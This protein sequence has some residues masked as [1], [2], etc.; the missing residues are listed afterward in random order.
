MS[1]ALRLRSIRAPGTAVACLPLAWLWYR[2][3]DHL[4]IEWSVNPQYSYGYAVP[5][6][7]LVLLWQR[8]RRGQTKEPGSAC[9]VSVFMNRARGA[10][11]VLLAILLLP[12]RLIQEANPEWRLMSW[13]FALTVIVLTLLVLSRH[14]FTARE[15]AFPILFFLVAVP[16]PSG[17]ETW[18]I[19][20]LT[21]LNVATTIE[22]LGFLNVPAF[23]HGSVI[24]I[25]TGSVG[26][27]EACSGLRSF[28]ATLMVSL[29]LGELYRLTVLRR[30]GLCLFGFGL[31]FIFN[32]SRITLLTWVAAKKGSAAIGSWHDSAGL[33][34]LGASLFT[35]W[36]AALL[37]RGQPSTA[38]VQTEHTPVSRI[39]AS[40][41]VPAA[42]CVWLGVVEFGTEGWYRAHEA[43]LGP[44][45]TW[46]VAMPETNPTF[47]SPPLSERAKQIL[48]YNEAQQGAWE[49]DAG[50]NWHAIFLHWNPG[51][52]AVHLAKGH[53]PEVCLT[54]AGHD[55]SWQ[56]ESHTF[57]V[58]GLEL[59][60]R[61]YV[62]NE[63]EG[64]VHV[65]YCLW[66]DHSPT[67]NFHTM[68]LTYQNRLTPV[69]AGCR[70]S[71]QR[72]LEIA[73]GGV[74]DEAKAATALQEELSKLIMR[75]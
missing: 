39:P 47:Q 28:Q 19:Q 22:I 14:G 40:I 50:L 38:D 5:F 69:F 4:R 11:I 64:P 61:S 65:F 33:T 70:N 49:D 16:W 71:G 55:L 27:D 18:L 30:F 21:R 59:P 17:P 57:S 62:F 74:E 66:D 67:R 43:K 60:F 58:D 35:L 25:G 37:M 3:I 9:Q 41:F 46:T 29:F 13:C 51:R 54:A 44:P 45:V 32:L 31:S 36:L 23:Q 26:V 73:I 56:S 2:L 12:I 68:N 10:A 1:L 75:N 52:T 63:P 7:C 24:E 15:L 42:L 53:T 20:R 72:S 6:L 34:V 48:R 8:L